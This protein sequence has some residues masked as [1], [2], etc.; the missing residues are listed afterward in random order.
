[1]EPWDVELEHA[2]L[3]WDASLESLRGLSGGLPKGKRPTDIAEVPPRRCR[4][5][6]SLRPTG[7]TV[8]RKSR[9][10]DIFFKRKNIL[11]GVIFPSRRVLRSGAI[12]PEKPP[13]LWGGKAEGPEPNGQIDL[14]A[15]LRPAMRRCKEENV[16]RQQYRIAALVG[17]DSS[18][19]W[20]RMGPFNGQ[21]LPQGAEDEA[22]LQVSPDLTTDTTFAVAALRAHNEVRKK[23]GVPPLQWSEI[24][25]GRARMYADE[26]CCGETPPEDVNICWHRGA[27]ATESAFNAVATWHA[28]GSAF[29]ASSVD[30]GV[31]RLTPEA[32]AY[33][34][35]LWRS[36]THVGMNLDQ[37]GRVVAAV[38]YPP[39]T[40]DGPFA[41]N[42]MPPLNQ[43]L[44]D[45]SAT[46]STTISSSAILGSSLTTDSFLVSTSSTVKGSIEAARSA[47][48][49]VV[50][51]EVARK[52]DKPVW[53]SAKSRADRRV[54]Q[55]GCA[56]KF[57]TPKELPRYPPIS[58][59]ELWVLKGM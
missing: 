44:R 51:D 17:V 19:A 20:T 29:D 32:F 7:N 10:E 49:K 8:W 18:L 30:A 54:Y 6:T 55:N 2:S 13:V 46:L 39:A 58:I 1:M 35:L 27:S 4:S 22:A 41:A 21:G 15:V 16:M 45:S 59:E 42:V 53:R 25:A 56:L 48:E 12:A 34:L 5:A 57:P 43:P 9:D 28:G 11:G 14:D 38:Y 47:S 33:T 50:D 3:Q 31:T 23:H 40:P 26:V 24:L 36:T 37:S 52:V